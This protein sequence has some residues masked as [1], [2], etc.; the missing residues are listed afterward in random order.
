[1]VRPARRTSRGMSTKRKRL[2]RG[3]LPSIL[4]D[5]EG[6]ELGARRSPRLPFASEPAIEDARRNPERSTQG[7]LRPGP[8]HGHPKQSATLGSLLAHP[9]NVDARHRQADCSDLLTLSS[10]KP[11]PLGTVTDRDGDVAK[12]RSH[13]YEDFV[14]RVGKRIN[15]RRDEAGLSLRDLSAR[16]GIN[17]ATLSE[18]ENGL[19]KELSAGNFFAI[20]EALALDPL[21]AWYGETRK[22]APKA[23]SEPPPASTR[24]ASKTPPK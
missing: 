2:P 17:I 23:Q 21:I 13:K 8:L 22:P 19:Q 1:M 3:K 4:R 14:R 24:R 9:S 6:A 7:S 15:T 20:C 5:A 16:T 12:G 18:I 10:T 11:E